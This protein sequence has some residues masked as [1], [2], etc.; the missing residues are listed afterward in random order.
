MNDDEDDDDNVIEPMM[1]TAVREIH[2]S[3]NNTSHHKYT[4]HPALQPLLDM[5]YECTTTTNSTTTTNIGTLRT[6]IL[7]A[8]SD[9]EIFQGFDQLYAL[10]EPSLSRVQPPHTAAAAVKEGQLLLQTL[11]LFS[12][13]WY[14]DYYDSGGGGGGGGVTTTPAVE[15]STTTTTTTTE[16][17]SPTHHPHYITLT[18]SQLWKLRQLTVVSLVQQACTSSHKA[19]TTTM[20]TTAGKDHEISSLKPPTGIVSYEVLAR[21]CGFITALSS[22][23]TVVEEDVTM[24]DTPPTTMKM[25]MKMEK[26]NLTRE[27]LRQVE[28]LL[29][30]CI[31]AG[32]I[33]GQLCQQQQ[34]F[35]VSATPT[36]TMTMTTS[37]SS[38]PSSSSSSSG[39]RQGGGGGANSLPSTTTTTTPPLPC[40]PRDVSPTDIPSLLQSLATFQTNVQKA[41]ETLHT[42]QSHAQQQQ[43]WDSQYWKDVDLKITKTILMSSTNSGSHN[44]STTAAT[45]VAGGSGTTTTL[46][47]STGFSSSENAAAAG[48]RRTGTTTTTTTGGGGRPR[49]TPSSSARQTKR[50][51]GGF[52]G[53]LSEAFGR[54]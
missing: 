34:V 38:A 8:L 16:P 30:S 35:V 53:A 20:T 9:S 2:N 3:Q 18:E 14:R 12:Y 31:Y 36:T 43:V 15:S 33:S 32:I 1:S 41:Q 50:S 11:K 47:S 28:E 26:G 6:L 37:T 23:S 45:A 27:A 52:S 4:R 19:T 51:R 49:H 22:S 7:K 40:R 24:N 5:A 17:S 44:S 25:T 54:Y 46:S 13:G 10:V 39:R 29:I 42:S 48:S 21:E